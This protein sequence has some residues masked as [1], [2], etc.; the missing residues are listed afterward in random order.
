MEEAGAAANTTGLSKLMSMISPQF[1]KRKNKQTGQEPGGK[2]G[3]FP[4]FKT[5][6]G[7]QNNSAQSKIVTSSDMKGQDSGRRN[8]K[9]YEESKKTYMASAFSYKD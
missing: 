9:L 8:S 1:G 4:M 3:S 2:K 6:L 7:G 5:F